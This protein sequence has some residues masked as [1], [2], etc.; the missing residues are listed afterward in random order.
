MPSL[1]RIILE[2]RIKLFDITEEGKIISKSEDELLL[3]HYQSCMTHADGIIRI[4]QMINLINYFED[5]EWIND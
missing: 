2:R 5:K 4:E 3:K 1:L